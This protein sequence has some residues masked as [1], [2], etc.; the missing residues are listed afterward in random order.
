MNDRYFLRENSQ[1]FFRK[2]EED[3]KVEIL[4]QESMHQ[5]TKKLL[6]S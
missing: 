6:H 1:L 5:L 4:V 2:R 3:N